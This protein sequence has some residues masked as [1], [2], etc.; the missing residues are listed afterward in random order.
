VFV[1]AEKGDWLC[2]CV[3]VSVC[4]QSADCTYISS[5]TFSLQFVPTLLFPHSNGILILNVVC[6]YVRTYV[7]V[8]RYVRMYVCMYVCV[9]M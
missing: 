8:C 1:S 9:C 6:M 7:Y 2:V 3:C 5:Y 4:L